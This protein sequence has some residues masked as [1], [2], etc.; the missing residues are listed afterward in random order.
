MISCGSRAFTRLRSEIERRG[1]ILLGIAHG[2]SAD[3]LA[4][5]VDR[6]GEPSSVPAAL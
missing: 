6:V 2:L 3:V 5:G 1:D 4:A